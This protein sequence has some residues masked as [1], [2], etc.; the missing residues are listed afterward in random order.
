MF[1]LT[2]VT[3]ELITRLDEPERVFANIKRKM[4]SIYSPMAFESS[5]DFIVDCQFLM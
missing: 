2:C 5:K 4:G 1:L 3:Y